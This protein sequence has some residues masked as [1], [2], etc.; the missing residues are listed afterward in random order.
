[1]LSKHIMSIWK[2]EK[3]KYTYTYFFTVKLS[4]VYSVSLLSDLEPIGQLHRAV[5]RFLSIHSASLTCY[6]LHGL[7]S[8]T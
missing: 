3:P 6:S 2:S 5:R 1:M 8:Y 4:F 7:S